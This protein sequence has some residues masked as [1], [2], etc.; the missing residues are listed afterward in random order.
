M[1]LCGTVA[2]LGNKLK[3]ILTVNI[4]HQELIFQSMAIQD[5]SA[6]KKNLFYECDIVKG[7]ISWTC[8]KRQRSPG[9]TKKR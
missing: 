7:G 2:I 8:L 4:T 9:M 5:H 3:S 1:T 6:C